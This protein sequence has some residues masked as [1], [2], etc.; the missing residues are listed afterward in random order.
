MGVL[1]PLC[2][3]WLIFLFAL[4]HRSLPRT[5]ASIFFLTFVAFVLVSLPVCFLRLVAIGENWH[6]GFYQV[7]GWFYLLF[8][9]GSTGICLNLVSRY[10][11]FTGIVCA[12][13]RC[14]SSNPIVLLYSG[15]T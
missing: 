11:R 9:F 10:K 13:D 3:Y 12:G 14:E 1:F 5:V 7:V 8:R 2:Y 6:V 4:L 15:S